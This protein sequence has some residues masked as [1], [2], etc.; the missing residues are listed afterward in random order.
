MPLAIMFYF[1]ARHISDSHQLLIWHRAEIESSGSLV[2][3]ALTQATLRHRKN[4][5]GNRN[6]SSLSFL[7]AALHG[8]HLVDKLCVSDDWIH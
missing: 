1:L 5:G 4:H 3:L 7:Q 6:S 2:D 8:K